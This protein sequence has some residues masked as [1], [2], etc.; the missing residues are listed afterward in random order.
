MASKHANHCNEKVEIFIGKI[1]L[2]PLA[3]LRLYEIESMNMANNSYK[4]AQ[5]TVF[6]GFEGFIELQM[7]KGL[8]TKFSHYLLNA[9]CMFIG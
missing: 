8:T 4:H 6:E 9:P 3:K 5:R 1:I 7:C 2:V